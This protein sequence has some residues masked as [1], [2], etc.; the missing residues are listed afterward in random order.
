MIRY[1]RRCIMPETKPDI[2]FDDGVCSACR[3]FAA[4]S[5]SLSRSRTPLMR[6]EVRRLAP[7]QVLNFPSKPFFVAISTARLQPTSA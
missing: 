1:C 2:F 3:H 4:R 6:R 7:A 5:Y